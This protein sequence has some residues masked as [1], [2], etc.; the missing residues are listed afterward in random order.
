MNSVRCPAC[1]EEVELW[2]DEPAR[3]CRRC[4]TT[5]R[6]PL[7]DGGCTKWCPKAKECLGDD[8]SPGKAGE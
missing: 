2:K 6:N 5:V 7:L 4:G 3:A 1:G 8:R